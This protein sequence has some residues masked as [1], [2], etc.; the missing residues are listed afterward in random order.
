[1]SLF[2]LQQPECNFDRPDQHRG[3]DAVT[4]IVRDYKL[5]SIGTVDIVISFWF[6]TRVGFLGSERAKDKPFWSFLAAL[7]AEGLNIDIRKLEKIS[8]FFEVDTQNRIRV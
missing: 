7:P 8:I 5:A 4:F 6:L 2:L 3:W 1:M